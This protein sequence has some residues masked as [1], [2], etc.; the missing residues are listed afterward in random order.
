MADLHLTTP[1]LDDLIGAYSG[2]SGRLSRACQDIATGAADLGSDPLA[3]LVSGFA[4]SWK[5]G[6]TQLGQH[7]HD[8][9]QLL[10]QVGSAFDRL[11]R[12][13]AGA[14]TRGK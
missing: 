11:D 7:G 3:G 5:Y 9:A 6:L 14:L 12:E 13:L 1:V 4:G 10:Q 8:C 2:F